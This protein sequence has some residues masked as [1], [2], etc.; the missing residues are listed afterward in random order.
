MVTVGAVLALACSQAP[1][2]YEPSGA[3]WHPRLERLFVVSDE[4]TLSMMR[5]DGGEIVHWELPGD[6]EAV[7][8]ADPASE[9]IYI[10]VEHPDAVIEFDL[11][12]G[13][14]RRRF[15]LTETLVGPDARGLEAMT[16]VEGELYV[17]HQHDGR[18]YRF[19]LGASLTFLGTIVPLE[20]RNDLSGLD[21]DGRLYALYDGADV[22]RVMER[23]GSFIE[24]WPAPGEGQEGLALGADSIFIADDTTGEILRYPTSQSRTPPRMPATLGTITTRSGRSSVSFLALPPPM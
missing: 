3:V 17:G 10:G 21:W 8:I 2:R 5:A 1:E 15:D 12:R 23:D 9:L 18:I 7:A 24:E 6:L 16:F 4:G 13:E 22:I 11:D 19:A 20:G 14:V